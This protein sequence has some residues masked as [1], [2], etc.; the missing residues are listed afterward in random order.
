MGSIVFLD[1]P[2]PFLVRTH[3]ISNVGI[4]GLFGPR[5]HPRT[6]YW[7]QLSKRISPPVKSASVTDAEYTG[8][9]EFLERMLPKQIAQL[10]FSG[11]ERFAIAAESV[12]NRTFR[13]ASP[14]CHL[15]FTF[16]LQQLVAVG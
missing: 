7:V 11:P 12:R 5:S 3:L 1:C 9:P 14:V 15:D 8:Q 10:E 6:R 13:S 2:L 16:F 4:F